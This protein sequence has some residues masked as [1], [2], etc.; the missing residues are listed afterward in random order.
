MN[1]LLELARQYLRSRTPRERY[2]LGLVVTV[3]VLGLVYFGIAEPLRARLNAR[4]REVTKLQEEKAEALERVQ[5]VAPLR[6]TLK[7]V[8]ARITPGKQ[9]NLFTVLETIASQANVKQ[10]L[11]SIKPTQA[12]GNEQYPETRVEV[13]LKGATLEQTV[14][15]LYRIETAPMHLIVRSIRIKSRPDSTGKLDVTLSVSSF[16]RA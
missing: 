12:A 6:A 2:A 9:T 11:D 5:G 7:A 16:E 10:N 15:L 4:E 3:L 1:K 13:S 14:Q 8:E